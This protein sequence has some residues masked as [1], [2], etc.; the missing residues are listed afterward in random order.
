M[1]RITYISL[2]LLLTL[3]WAGVSQAAVGDPPVQQTVCSVAATSSPTCTFGSAVTSGNTLIA[4]VAIRVTQTDTG[5]SDTV[6]GAWTCDAGANHSDGSQKAM[7]CYFNNTGAGTPQLTLSLGGNSA[8]YWNISEWS[9]VANSSPQDA[10][11]DGGDISNPFVAT[12]GGASLTSTT[13]GLIVCVF[14]GA[15]NI[16]AATPA[17]GFTALTN[18]GVRDYFEYR[19]GSATTT[20][21]STSLTGPSATAGA[22]MAFKEEAAGGS[23]TPR[24]ML[25]GVY[26]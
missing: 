6:N 22:M 20:D 3:W 24:G 15:G 4:L 19:V 7:I 21:C 8:T 9:G 11:Q 25:L 1:K 12:T 23:V 2:L 10:V 14:A 5:I 26:P 16:T 18:N 13:A 17:T